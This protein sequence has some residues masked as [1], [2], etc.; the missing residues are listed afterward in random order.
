[1]TSPI[2]IVMT[3]WHRPEITEKAIRSL[4][5]NTPYTPFR[6]IVIDNDSPPEMQDMLCSLQDEG[7]IDK[8]VFNPTNLGLEPSRNQGLT[9]VHSELFISTDND[10]IPEKPYEGKDWLQRLIELMDKHPDYAAISPRYPVMIGTGNIYEEADENGEELVGFPH[11]GGSLRIMRTGPTRDVGGWRDEVGGR[12]TEERYICG[13]L[14]DAGWSTGF[15]AK[16]RCLHLFGD[17]ESDR[18]GYPKEWAPGD[19]GHSDIWH[20]KLASGDDPDEIKEYY[21]GQ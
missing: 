15:A 7:L 16:V 5:A 13:K 2:D 18:W 12:G 6:L 1:M 14:R 8:L 11:P 10:C 4:K 20:P 17:Q 3:T 19:T 9:L 21:D